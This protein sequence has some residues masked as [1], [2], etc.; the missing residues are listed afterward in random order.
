MYVYIYIYIHT[1]FQVFRIFAARLPP[2]ELS[3]AENQNITTPNC[4]KIRLLI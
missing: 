2:G 1:C 4:L 3:L